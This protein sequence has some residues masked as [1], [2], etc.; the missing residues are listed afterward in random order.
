MKYW[1]GK[2]SLPYVY[3]DGGRSGA[4]FKGSTGDCVTRAVAIAS[5]RPY[6]EVYA[7][8]AKGTGFQRAGKCGKRA[9]S[10]RNGIDVTRKWFKDYMRSIGFTFVP[11]M[12]I[13]SGCKVHLLKGELPQG[14]LVVSLSKHYAAV[15]DGVIRDTGDPTRTTSK[16]Q[17]GV[18]SLAHRCVYGYWVLA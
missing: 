11:T 12:T 9:A 6:A 14:R 5:G 2:E 8:L 10:A 18:T 1:D 7:A 16:H 3:D 17:D 15:I 4:G 13:G